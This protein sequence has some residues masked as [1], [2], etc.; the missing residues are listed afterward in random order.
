MYNATWLPYDDRMLWR[1]GGGVKVMFV[2]K[3]LHPQGEYKMA[4]C[5]LLPY[6]KNHLNHPPYTHPTLPHMH[7][8]FQ[9]GYIYTWYEGHINLG[10]FCFPH[11]YQTTT[12]LMSPFV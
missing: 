5:P 11:I 8:L 9:S 10:L 2:K 4:F 12:P 6:P 3:H 1:G 7:W